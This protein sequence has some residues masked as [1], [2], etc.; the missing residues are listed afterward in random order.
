[1]RES[2][3]VQRGVFYK[4]HNV[5]VNGLS[6]GNVDDF[7]YLRQNINMNTNKKENG[8]RHKEE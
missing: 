7:I 1:M 5:F 3:F 4:T 6:M 8:E 2:K